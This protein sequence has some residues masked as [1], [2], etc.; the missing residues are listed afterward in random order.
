MKWNDFFL[1]LIL[2]T[3]KNEYL[4]NT[5]TLKQMSAF[6]LYVSPIITF[7]KIKLP[8]YISKVELKAI[9]VFLTALTAA[10]LLY[11]MANPEVLF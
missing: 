6:E 7:M 9:F 11:L 4:T 1:F 2:H 10:R 3:R 5:K 8:F